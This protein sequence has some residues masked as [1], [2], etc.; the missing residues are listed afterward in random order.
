M[1]RQHAAAVLVPVALTLGEREHADGR[2]LITALAVGYDVAARIDRAAEPG[3]HYAHS[4]HPSAVFGHFGAAATA[5]HLLRLDSKRMTNALGLA[6]LNAS[7]LA[8]WL[9]SA[10][11]D[12]CPYVI[13]MAAQHGVLAGLL[14]QMGMG[15]PVGIADD[16]KYTIYDAFTG[17][18]HLD[19]LT[20]DLGQVF[21]ITDHSG[22]KPYPCC[23]GYAIHTAIAALLKIV[24][25]NNL[26]PA[27]IAEIIDRVSP[28]QDDPVLLQ[29]HCTE[30][31]LAVAAGRGEIAPEAIVVDYRLEDEQVGDLFRRTRMVADES[32]AALGPAAATVEVHTRDGR[33]FRETG[34][35]RPG[36]PQDP[37]TAEQV[38][39]K[40]LRLATSRLRRSDAEHVCDV[41]GRLD[42]L[43][44]AAELVA[45]LVGSD[46]VL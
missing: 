39:A 17:A 40:F 7:G 6:G 36:S 44:D 20:R 46:R 13:G 28:G 2:A 21:W 34:L 15:G 24:Q 29:S 23:G 32:I 12:S 10:S 30:Y 8:V 41:I 33:V 43:A 19:E 31:V 35:N 27:D 45:L 11:E 25:N 38:E 14:A 22:F 42:E 37:L 18:M 3:V 9:Q 26:R 16:G 4:F 5:G 1:C